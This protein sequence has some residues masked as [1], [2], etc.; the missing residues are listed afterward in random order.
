MKKG[1]NYDTGFLPE[2]GRSRVRFDR[3]TARREMRVIAGELHCTVVRVSGA[4][5]VRLTVAA[6]E[7]AAAGLEIYYAPFPVD[8]HPEETLELYAESAR[9]AEALRRTGAEVV[10]VTGCETSAFGHGYLPG[11]TYGERMAAM[12]GADADWWATV[13]PPV[14]RRLDTFLA[15]AAATVRPLFGGRVTYAAGPWEFV[16]WTPFDLVGA[17]AYRAAYNAATFRDEVRGLF[18]HGKPVVI[19]EFGTC[20]YTGAADRGGSAWEVP[21]GA[22]PDEGEQARYLEELIDVFE[23]EGAEA[24]MWFTFAGYTRVG[25]VADLGSY[26]VVS[27]L[28][29]TRW[30]P[31]Q[32]FHAMA[33]RYARS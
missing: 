29:E 20:A 22:A 14:V 17:D 26:G 25:G 18:K 15:E 6:E 1:I 3:E 10:L 19:T 13:V 31:R 33:A 11:A 28:D 9:R 5:P 23:Q 16:D 12:G 24:A 2:P 21:A 4:D 30:R 7:A 32:V 27:M 8:L